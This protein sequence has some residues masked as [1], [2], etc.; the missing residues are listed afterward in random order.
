MTVFFLLNVTN[1]YS[2]A[3]LPARSRTDEQSGRRSG[4]IIGVLTII[5]IAAVLHIIASLIGQAKQT[6]RYKDSRN[7]T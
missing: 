5:F 3:F 4:I 7:A 2:Q 6:N 1:I